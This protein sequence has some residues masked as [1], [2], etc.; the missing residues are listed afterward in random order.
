MGRVVTL[1]TSSEPATAVREHS[2]R[3]LL[4]MA[5]V[6]LV[7]APAGA[8]GA[9]PDRQPGDRRQRLQPDPLAEPLARGAP[10]LGVLPERLRR[11]H[12]QP[13][14]ADRTG[15]ARDASSRCITGVWYILVYGTSALMLL[16]SRRPLA[17][18]A[19]RALVR[20]LSRAAAPVRAAH[21]RPLQ[22]DVRG[23]LD[24]DRAHRRQL[25]QH[26]HRQA[27]RARPRRG[28]LCARG[29]RRAHR[30]VPRARCGS[31][32]CSASASRRSTPCW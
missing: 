19:D 1:V 15:D 26:P 13:R 28:R 20:R 3:M 6:L 23:A 4:G 18:A 24:A 25:H 31:T 21:A 8:D 30:A 17:G 14:D 22:G 11:P 16:A 29:D 10:V 32:R 2:G 27:V 9:E 12:R 7:R 5:V